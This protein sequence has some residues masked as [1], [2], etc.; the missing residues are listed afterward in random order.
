MIYS[1]ILKNDEQR[2]TSHAEKK[3]KYYL[4]YIDSV[5]TKTCKIKSIAMPSCSRESYNI[6]IFQETKSTLSPEK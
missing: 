5:C 3:E 6:S 1:M 4:Q 2:V